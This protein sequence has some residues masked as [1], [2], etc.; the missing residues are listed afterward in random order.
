MIIETIGL[1]KYFKVE[2]KQGYAGYL[3]VVAHTEL[4]EILP[5]KPL[6]PAMLIVPG[7]GYTFVSQREDEAVAL[8]FLADGYNCFTLDYT[9]NVA[10]YPVQLC[11]I[12]M[13]VAFI[14]EN[15]NKYSI[16]AGKICAV[17]FS[18]GGH[19]VGSLATRYNDK[20][21]L[22]IIGK[23]AKDVRPDAVIP[24]YAVVSFSDQDYHETT[25]AVITGGDKSLYE[26][27]DVVK[28]VRKDC[29]PAFIWA[30]K[31]DDLV[32]VTNSLKLA[33]AYENAGA[34]Y[35]LHVFERG[36]HGLSTGDEQ[37]NYDKEGNGISFEC[38]KWISLAK[39]WLKN[40]GFE[41]KYYK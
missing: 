21:M 35:E 32:P 20:E 23:T 41:V 10:G 36:W 5:V 22:A 1:Y 11:E 13:A 19:L 12:A 34:S 4:T 2:R 6:R 26:Y 7:G 25:R 15:A 29:P 18:A 14:R 28:N 27:L 30:T 37:A 40:K 33:L 9:V 16:F 38:S 8:K 31:E 24:C 17:G 39:K 3:K